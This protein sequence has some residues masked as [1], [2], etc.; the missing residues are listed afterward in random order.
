[1]NEN[2]FHRFEACLDAKLA[3]RLLRMGRHGR[4]ADV[5]NA[6]D[7]FAPDVSPHQPENLLL[8]VR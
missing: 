8:T 3:A 7:L 6:R 5:Q 2:E 4:G 1:M